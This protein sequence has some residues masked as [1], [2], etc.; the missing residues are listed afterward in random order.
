M[1]L[2]ETLYRV[3]YDQSR[4]TGRRL[5][6]VAHVHLSRGLAALVRSL[7]VEPQ[8]TLQEELTAARLAAACA[9]LI[10]CRLPED[11]ALETQLAAVSRLLSAPT[12][13]V[14]HLCIDYSVNVT[15]LPL[16]TPEP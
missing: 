12:S 15:R 11:D 14:I 1:S 6:M 5:A 16:A 7:D 3:L 4:G 10:Q 9:R 2:S 13:A 8:A